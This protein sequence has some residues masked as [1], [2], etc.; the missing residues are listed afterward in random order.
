MATRQEVF[1][2]IDTEREYQDQVWRAHS[3]GSEQPNPLSIGEWILCAEDYLA[4][5]RARWTTEAKPEVE[6]LEIMR[7]VAG[8]AVHCMEQH[9]APKR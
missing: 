6:T 3:G 9:G 4:Q 2:A 1:E 7:K 5:A 8:I